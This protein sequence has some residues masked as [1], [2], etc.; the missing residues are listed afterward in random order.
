MISNILSSENEN[1][2]SYNNENIYFNENNKKEKELNSFLSPYLTTIEDFKQVNDI[3][4]FLLEKDYEGI[5]GQ[6]PSVLKI[7]NNIEGERVKEI[8]E[9]TIH[10]NYFKKFIIKKSKEIFHIKKELKL[11]RPKKTQL[12]KESIINIKKIML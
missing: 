2:S 4:E 5:S 3:F 8:L 11:G 9:K 10:N 1:N 7:N 6:L 12:K